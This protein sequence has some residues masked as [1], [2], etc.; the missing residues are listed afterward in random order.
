MKRKIF[1]PVL[2]VAII[3]AGLMS[4][5]LVS[6]QDGT[7]AN[8]LVAA[9]AAKFNLNQ[10]DVQAVFDEERNKHHTQMKQQMEQ[11]LT[12]A[13]TEGKITETQKQAIITHF[14]EMKGQ[15]IEKGQFKEMTDDEIKAFKESKKAEMDKWLS[16]NGLTQEVLNE[17]MGHPKGFGGKGMMFKVAP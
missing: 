12:Q 8:S 7:G 9:I 4:T 1:F 10:G 6:A 2:A 17:V 13:V 5:N 14:T 11:K 16:D 3:A 15:K